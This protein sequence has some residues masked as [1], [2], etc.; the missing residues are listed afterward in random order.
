MLTSTLVGRAGVRVA[1]I[2]GQLAIV[3]VAAWGWWAQFHYT[4]GEPPTTH[5]SNGNLVVAAILAGGLLFL[6][7]AR[8]GLLTRR[9]SDARR[10]RSWGWFAGAI[11]LTICWLLP[12]FFREQEF[13]ER[14]HCR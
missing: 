4:D 11:F 13:L 6:A 3:G 14:H 12:S 5:F 8:P 10:L 7:R 2:G 1:S 9:A